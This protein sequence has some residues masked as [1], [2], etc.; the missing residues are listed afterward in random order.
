MIV[1][2]GDSGLDR[3]IIDGYRILEADDNRVVA[4]IAYRTHRKA[5][6]GHPINTQEFLMQWQGRQLVFIS[7]KGIFVSK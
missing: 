6:G 1:G 2:S 5:M 7:H 3:P 4:S